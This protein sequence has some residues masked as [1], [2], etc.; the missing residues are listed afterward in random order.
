MRLTIT[1]GRNSTNGSGYRKY[2]ILVV[3][4]VEARSFTFTYYREATVSY[5]GWVVHCAVIEG[6]CL[7][8]V[9]SAFRRAIFSFSRRTHTFGRF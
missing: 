9:Y 8:F 4:K 2:D 3:K 7:R 6:D 5:D 1:S